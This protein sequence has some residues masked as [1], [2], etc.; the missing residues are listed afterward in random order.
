[1]PEFTGVVIRRVIDRSHAGVPEHAHDWP[2][3]SIFVIGSYLNETELGRSVIASP[4]V[5]FYRS[6]A[7]HRNTVGGEGFEQIEIEFDPDWLGRSFV[8]DVPV[9]R[10][11]ACDAT[12]LSES[13]A[14]ACRSEQTLRA[15]LRDVLMRPDPGVRYERASWLSTIE[16]RLK[17][18]TTLSVADLAREVGRHPSWVGYAYRRA[19]GEGLRTTTARLRVARTAYLLRETEEPIAHIALEAGFCDQS[20]LNRTVR[21][22]LG[23]SPTSVRDDRARFRNLA[24][25]AGKE[26]GSDRPPTRGR[27]I[28]LTGRSSDPDAPHYDAILRVSALPI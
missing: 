20:H 24:A 6:G 17:E 1:M 5:V 4:S 3:V 27:G 14:L 28:S 11:T 26:A 12:T 25:L 23:R 13:L 15:T 7:A 8:P 16:R 22:V 10:W 21:Q 9:K 2:V 18:D 19:T